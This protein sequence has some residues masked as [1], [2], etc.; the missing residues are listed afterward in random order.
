MRGRGGRAGERGGEARTELTSGGILTV[1][2]DWQEWKEIQGTPIETD[3]AWR[4]FEEWKSSRRE[5]GIRFVSQTSRFA[6]LGKL[7][8]PNRGTIQ[9][10]AEG[11]QAT[12]DLKEARFTFGPF[13]TWPR[14]PNPPMVEVIALQAY[15]PRGAWLV[16]VE[17]LKPDAIPVPQLPG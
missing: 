5:I 11:A 16:M 6:A 8:S 14:Y 17:G 12:F 10:Q 13:Q 15:L 9:I 3:Q 7:R 1:M 2:Q 4:M